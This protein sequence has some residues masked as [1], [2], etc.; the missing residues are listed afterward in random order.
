MRHILLPRRTPLAFLAALGACQ[1]SG[2]EPTLLAPSGPP[3]EVA[4]GSWTT[5]AKMPSDRFNTTTATVTNAQGRTILYVIGGKNPASTAPNCGGGLSTVQSYNSSANQWTRRTPFPSPIQHTN[6]AG[7]IKGKIYLTGG[8]VRFNS[9]ESWT[10]MYNPATDKWTQRAP[11]PVETWGGHTGVI[12]D[13]LYVLSGCDG[14]EDCGN[15]SNVFFGR[16]NPTTN[17][18]TSLPLPPSGAAHLFSASAVIG[19][20][21]YVVGRRPLTDAIEVY[22]P[23][24]NRWTS[25][26]GKGSDRKFVA[27]AAIAGKLYMIA[28]GN[29]DG[30]L[31]AAT[32][33]YDP[34]RNTWRNLAPAPRSGIGLAA[35][36][37][38]V[39][40]Q[41]R[42]ALIGGARPKNAFLFRP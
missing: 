31:V 14:Q 34:A 21:F 29:R 15:F 5:A 26:P 10:W 20:M 18:W 40:G 23:A 35:G 27:S 37:V 41:P 6:G 39:N 4:A 3:A 38:V 22:N 9:I 17:S 7:V 16:Y 2:T 13:K 33:V 1:E 25:L 12:Q 36:R 42:I 19:G 30:E 28:G 8:C 32:S 24:T 11:M